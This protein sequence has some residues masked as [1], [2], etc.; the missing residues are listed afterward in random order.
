[1]NLAV[2]ALHSAVFLVGSLSGPR[3]LLAQVRA[4]LMQDVD[5][6]ARQ[7]FQSHG[8]VQRHWSDLHPVFNPGWKTAV[9]DFVAING[10]TASAGADFSPYSRA[11]INPTATVTIYADSRLRSSLSTSTSPDI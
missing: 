8:A 7:P 1:M 11:T 6:P 3:Q 10:T 9:V 2:T 5:S 4:A